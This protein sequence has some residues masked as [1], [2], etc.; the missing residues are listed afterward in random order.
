MPWRFDAAQKWCRVET[1]SRTVTVANMMRLS[2]SENSSSIP[3]RELS[4]AGRGF[5]MAK[6]IIVLA[7]TAGLI[8]LGLISTHRKLARVFRKDVGNS[9][10]LTGQPTNAGG[11]LNSHV[12]PGQN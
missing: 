3:M 9:G 8:V 7:C 2:R 12:A 5:A 6:W 4:R 10:T 1:R 11:S